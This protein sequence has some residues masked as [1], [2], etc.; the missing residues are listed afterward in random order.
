MIRR[1]ARVVPGAALLLAVLAHGAGA[2]SPSPSPSPSPVPTPV[3]FSAHAHANVTV[4][5][6]GTAYAGSVQLGIAQLGSRTRV[7]LISLKSDAFPVPPITGTLVIDRA[8]NTITA[9]SDTTKLY[10]VQPFLARSQP[11]RSPSPKPGASA[12]PVVRGVSPFAKLD[13]LELSV[14]L[15]GHT[16]TAGLATTGLALDLQVQ[17]KGDKGPSHVTAV[18]QLADD[19]AAFPV[20]VDISLEPGASPF[21]AKLNYALDDLSRTPPPPSRFAVPAGYAEAPSLLGVFFSGRVV[22]TPSPKPR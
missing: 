10:R 22:T 20:T 1:V 16:T 19:F 13:V 15:T 2:Q 21:A 4:T 5:S 7:D 6:Q 3:A 9:W 14:K 18:T 8:A 11:A 12:R 17:N